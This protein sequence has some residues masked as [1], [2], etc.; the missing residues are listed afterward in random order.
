MADPTGRDFS[1]VAQ[2]GISDRSRT[3]CND[4]MIAARSYCSDGCWSLNKGNTLEHVPPYWLQRQLHKEN[5]TWIIFRLCQAR[6]GSYFLYTIWPDVGK[7][8]HRP[9]KDL[10]IYEYAK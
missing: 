4:L 7:A 6:D 8:G 5:T 3:V 1:H 9:A 10:C 2:L